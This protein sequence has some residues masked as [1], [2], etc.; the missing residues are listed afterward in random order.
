[1]HKF[2]ICFVWRVRKDRNTIR[3]P[4][5]DEVRRFQ[6]ACEDQNRVI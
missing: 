5:L 6:H 4:A 2:L 1:M 3:E